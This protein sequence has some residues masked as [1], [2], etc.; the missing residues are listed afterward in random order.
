MTM[1][2]TEQQTAQLQKAKPAPEQQPDKIVTHR[3]DEKNPG[4]VRVEVF[5]CPKEL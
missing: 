4:G 2:M 3:E 5:R 1:A